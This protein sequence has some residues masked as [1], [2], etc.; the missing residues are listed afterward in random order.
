VVGPGVRSD[1]PDNRTLTVTGGPGIGASH[2]CGFV[3]KVSNVVIADVLDQEERTI[4]DELG[5][6]AIFSR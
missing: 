1:G 5:G 6:H 4:A 3:V 2:A